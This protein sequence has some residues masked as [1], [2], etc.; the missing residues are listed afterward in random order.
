MEIPLKISKRMCGANKWFGSIERALIRIP[1]ILR[2]KCKLN[3][4]DF[5]D[6]KT[7]TGSIISLQISSAYKQDV[8]EDSLHAYV[9]DEI[10]NLIGVEGET[11]IQELNLVNGITLGCDPEFFLIK[12]DTKE[13]IH[14]GKFFQRWGEIGYDHNGLMMEIRPLPSNN[15]HVVNRNMF[16]LINRARNMITNSSVHY[17]D[18]VMMYAASHLRQMTAGFHLHYGLP[19]QML[20]PNGYTTAVAIQVVKAMDYYVGVPAIIPEGETDCRRRTQPFV[21]YGKPGNYRLDNRTFEYRVPGGSLM[22]HPTLSTG[23][24]G[25]GAVVMED[26]V[27]RIYEKTDGLKD[28]SKMSRE[29]DIRQLYPNIPNVHDLFY[30]IC[31]FKTD[32]AMAHVK[33]IMNDIKQMVSY[34][35]RKESVDAYFNSILSGEVFNNDIEYNWRRFYNEGQQRKMDIFSTPFKTGVIGG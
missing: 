35:G 32:V 25:L 5:V 33:T 19:H 6:L 28:L 34:E 16:D 14:A 7:K 21:E 29:G 2:E 17:K 8:E 23:I 11:C 20:G 18:L 13:T 31:S 30:L 24:L 22:R 3:L 26:V 27:S 1:Q 4:G 10:F 15:E 12:R 9:V